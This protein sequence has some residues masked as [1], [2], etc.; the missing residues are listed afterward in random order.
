MNS[1]IDVLRAQADWMLMLSEGS[2]DNIEA[3]QRDSYRPLYVLTLT[4]GKDVEGWGCWCCIFQLNKCGSVC[5]H[6]QY[7]II[8]A[9]K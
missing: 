1:N 9:V 6:M 8:R 7:R 2:K 4:S 5:L 3:E